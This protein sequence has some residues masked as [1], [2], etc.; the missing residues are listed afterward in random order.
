MSYMV[1][2]EGRQAPKK[3]HQLY[4]DAQMEAK[5]LSEK[6]DNRNRA[7]Y[8]LKVV[9]ILKPVSSHQWEFLG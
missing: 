8:V 5:R 4:E 6:P 2:V 7:I 9:S 3:I 1:S